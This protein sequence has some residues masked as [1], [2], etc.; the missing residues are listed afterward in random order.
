VGQ[1]RLDRLR[2]DEERLRDLGVYTQ[3]MPSYELPTWEKSTA[4][5]QRRELTEDELTDL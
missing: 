4:T 5:L 1:V 2:R 3:A